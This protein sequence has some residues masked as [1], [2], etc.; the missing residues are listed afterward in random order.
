MVG[1]T[2]EID[3]TIDEADIET[4]APKYHEWGRRKSIRIEDSCKVHAI[5]RYAI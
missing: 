4:K 5:R 3:C 1:S 2:K